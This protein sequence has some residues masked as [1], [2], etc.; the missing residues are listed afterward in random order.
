VGFFASGLPE[1][2]PAAK[3]DERPD[4]GFLKSIAHLFFESIENFVVRVVT[5]EREKTHAFI[6]RL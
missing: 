5:T 4:F 2:R 6:E 3:R 1:S